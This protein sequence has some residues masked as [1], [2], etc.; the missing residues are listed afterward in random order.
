MDSLYR[1]RIEARLVDEEGEEVDSNDE[2]ETNGDVMDEDGKRA[3]RKRA[4]AP[5]PP[6][7]SL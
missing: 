6:L 7:S 3:R 5:M 2:E 4:S 1:V